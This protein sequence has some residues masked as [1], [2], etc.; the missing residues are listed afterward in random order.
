MA[1]GRLVHRRDR[2]LALH[3]RSSPIASG[4]GSSGRSS[5]PCAGAMVTG[6]DRPDRAGRTIGDTDIGTVLVA[7]PGTLIGLAVIYT[8]APVRNV[9]KSSV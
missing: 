2:A 3:G 4:P 6:G 5:A 8:S 7:I 9:W 1:A